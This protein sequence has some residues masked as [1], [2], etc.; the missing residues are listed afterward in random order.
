[1]WRTPGSWQWRWR[2]SRASTDCCSL[3][4]FLPRAGI[5]LHSR[6]LGNSEVAA[7]RRNAVPL[8][9]HVFGLM[10]GYSGL[11]RDHHQTWNRRVVLVAGRMIFDPR[12]CKSGIAYRP[13]HIPGTVR[14]AQALAKDDAVAA[15]GFDGERQQAAGYQHA[16]HLPQ[17]RRDIGQI[18][19]RVGGENEVG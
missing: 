7:L 16:L 1:M 12:Q 4:L 2:R 5:D 13:P 8:L 15:M 18:D 6:V 3:F 9:K 11:C 19:H 14:V 10:K 17:E